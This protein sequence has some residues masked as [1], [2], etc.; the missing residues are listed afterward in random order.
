MLLYIIRHGEPDYATDSLTENGRMQAVALANRLC[1]HGLDEVYS[2]PLGRARETAEPTCKRLG[3]TYKIEEWMNEDKVFDELSS[4][5][6]NGVR[7]WSFGCQNTKLI[8]TDYT[9]DNWYSNPVFQTCSSP[10]ECYKR[11]SDSSDDFILRLGYKRSGNIYEVISASEKRI[12]A[13]CHHGVSTVW[14]SHLLNIPPHIFWSSFDI[15][16]TGV[17]IIEFKNNTDGYT[18]PKCMSLSDLSHIYKENI[19]IKAAIEIF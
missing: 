17:T 9:M 15:H 1:A 13:F 14:L 8:K 6:E 2:S 5:D 16:H 11:M 18:A 7:D 12:A 3:L 10:I 4:V 19:Q